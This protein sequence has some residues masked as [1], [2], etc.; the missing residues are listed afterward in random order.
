VNSNGITHKASGNVN[1]HE[2]MRD[3]NCRE[4]INSS[5]NSHNSKWLLVTS[6]TKTDVY[7]S[8]QLMATQADTK[9]TP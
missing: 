8:F 4:R 6:I 7:I 2:M 9:G 3:Q 1:N 5:N